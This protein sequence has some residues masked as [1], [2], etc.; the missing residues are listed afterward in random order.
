[1]PILR[2]IDGSTHKVGWFK[3][4]ESLACK[5]EPTTFMSISRQAQFKTLAVPN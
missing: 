3:F 1:M 4:Y 2:E 5:T